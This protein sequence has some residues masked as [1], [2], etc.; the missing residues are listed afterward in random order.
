M[1]TTNEQEHN[2]EGILGLPWNRVI[3]YLI[4]WLGLFALG[5]LFV[6]NPAWIEPSA[7]VEPI[8]SNAMY[9]HGLLVGLAALV[10][11]VAAQALGVHSIKVKRFLTW[12]V[13]GATVLA[14][15]GGIFDRGGPTNPFWVILHIGGF[16]LLDATF[17]VLAVGLI[18]NLNSD[19]DREKRLPLWSAI[20]TTI[21]LELAALMGHLAGWIIEFGNYPTIL[22]GWAEFVGENLSTFQ[23]NLVTSHSHE[24]V[25]ALLALLAISAAWRFGYAKLKGTS[26]TLSRIGMLLVTGGVVIMTVIYVVGGLTSLEPP[27]LFVF[28]SGGV[29]GIAGDDLVT[30]VGVMLGGLLLL[31]STIAAWPRR[32]TMGKIASKKES[33]SRPALLFV[34][35]AWLVIVIAVVGAGY[36]IELNETFFG[37]GNTG[38]PGALSDAVFTFVHQDFAFFLIPSLIT[39]LLLADLTL[40]RGVVQAVARW[41]GIGTAVSLIGM[42][43]Y[44]FVLP[45][46]IHGP[47]YLIMMLG[48]AVISVGIIKLLIALW[49][50]SSTRRDIK[51]T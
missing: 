30:G 17:I 7:A 4:I 18:G 37:A 16:F 26:R 10:C 6:Q 46:Q 19:H 49:R 28:G 8:L 15:I 2:P 51:S 42:F 14:C 5:G 27:T 47:G 36:Y 9:F 23:A 40:D 33:G 31:A 13:V 20:L 39:L 35:W 41:F 29:N 24:I 34:V 43:V 1:R 32:S 25:I 3:V 45:N 44:V 38:A 50:V 12:S 22:G 11:L 21:S 48:F